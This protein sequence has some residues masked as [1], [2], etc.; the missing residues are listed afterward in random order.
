[1]DPGNGFLRPQCQLFHS[2]NEVPGY[3]SRQYALGGW[4]RDHATRPSMKCREMNPGNRP[5]SQQSRRRWPPSMKCRDMNPGNIT[6]TAIELP[7]AFPQ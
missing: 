3:E 2:L 1:M 6:G 4:A 5:P 7:R